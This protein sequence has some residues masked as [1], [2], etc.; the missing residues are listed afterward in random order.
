MA[1]AFAYFGDPDTCETETFLRHFDRFFDC[2]NVRSKCSLKGKKD[3]CAY[4]S[5]NDER[6]VVCL[7][8]IIKINISYLVFSVSGWKQ[9]SSTILMNGRELVCLKLISE[10]QNAA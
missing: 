1:N 2:L 5:A 4:T 3:L 8:A 6:L 10:Q 7:T 9:H